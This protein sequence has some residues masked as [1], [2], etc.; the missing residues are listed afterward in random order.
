MELDVDAVLFAEAEKQVASHPDLVGGA[1]GALAEDLEFPL[2]LGHFGID[3]FV[4]D[5]SSQAEVEMLFNDFASNA[6]DV[7]VADTGVVRTLRSRVTLLREAERTAILVKKYS[8]SKP[9]QASSSSRM[10]ARL[11]DGCG[12]TPSGIM[13]SHMTRA[14]LLRAGSG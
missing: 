6:A 13:T 12:V 14:P 1:L 2:A 3:A 8:C 5:A 7:L 9:N 11:F 4:V 10:V